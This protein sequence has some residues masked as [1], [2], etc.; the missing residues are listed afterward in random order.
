MTGSLGMKSF[1]PEHCF[2]TR[3]TTILVAT[4]LCLTAV[5]QAAQRN[6]FLLT[7]YADAPGGRPLVSGHYAA[8]LLELRSAPAATLSAAV[9]DK[10]NACVAYAALR[11]LPEAREACD[12]AVTATDRD[13]THSSGKVWRSW[14]DEDEFAAI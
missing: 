5:T 13:K 1:R 8:A 7:V 6:P 9:L 4:G 11:R 3:I 12:A 10:T 2:A 14:A